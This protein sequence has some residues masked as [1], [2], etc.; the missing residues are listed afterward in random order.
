[1]ARLGPQVAL[2]AEK[3]LTDSCSYRILDFGY[4]ELPRELHAVGPS[5]SSGGIRR[6]IS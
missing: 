3:P 6:T 5:R 4:R 1:M 2:A